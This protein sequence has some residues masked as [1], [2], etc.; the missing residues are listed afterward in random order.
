MDFPPGLVDFRP[1]TPVDETFLWGRL[2]LAIFVPPGQD[3]LLRE[4]IRPLELARCVEGWECTAVVVFPRLCP[5]YLLLFYQ[6]SAEKA[7]GQNF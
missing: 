4:L 1:L 2:H 7:S 3:P 6:V 5:N